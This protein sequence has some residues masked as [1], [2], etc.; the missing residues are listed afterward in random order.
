MIVNKER[1]IELLSHQD[2]RVRDEVARALERFFPKTTG[3][4][5][6]LLKTIDLFRDNCLAP[7]ARLKAFIPEEDDIPE[8]VSLI[9]NTDNQEND[10]SMNLHYHLTM[11]L[12]TSPFNILEKNQ[13]AFVFSKDLTQLY[14]MAKNMEEFKQKGLE[15]LWDELVS[16][17]ERCRD[18]IIEGNDLQHGQLITDGLLRY[19][20]QIKGKVIMLLAQEKP[21]NHHLQEY[22]IK[23][24][25][26][27]KLNET[28][29]Y[30]FRIFNEADFMDM[31]H[32]ECLSSLQDIGTREVVQEIEKLYGSDQNEKNALA[33]ILQ[34]IPYDYSE[35]LAIRLIK[36]EQDLTAKTF[37]ACSLC[38]IFSVNAVDIIKDMI[39]VKN[40]DPET[41]TLIDD[42]F[43]VYVYHDIPV[44]ELKDLAASDAGFVKEHW[45]NNP[46]VQAAQNLRKSLETLIKKQ[47]QE[48]GNKQKEIE[49]PNNVISLSAAKNRR[50]KMRK[51]IK[52]KTKR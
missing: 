39:R 35:N 7:A 22:M 30:L 10:M 51:R 43:T 33:E 37:L 29:K 28:V 40:Y 45:N 24:A 12:L 3:V 18:K 20:D 16:L 8:I 27:L 4:T 26:K 17:C 34:Y 19:K 23:L 38:D 11:S 42:L 32:G 13:N 25:G 50:R 31:V 6:H 41:A 9:N 46:G 52:N 21:D 1:L 2:S 47:T 14:E 15:Y 36:E 5:T 49:K 48:Q 44:E